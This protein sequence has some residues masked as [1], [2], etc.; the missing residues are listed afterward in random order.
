MEVQSSTVIIF[1]YTGRFFGP[2]IIRS[3][4]DNECEHVCFLSIVSN[5]H[6]KFSLSSSRNDF[7]SVDR[8]YPDYIH[9]LE[10]KEPPTVVRKE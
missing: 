8:V 9:I 2:P 10:F 5:W 4:N 7:Q 6:G 1:P 3:L